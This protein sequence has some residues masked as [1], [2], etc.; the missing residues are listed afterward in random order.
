M[1]KYK[2]GFTMLELSVTLM[3][4]GMMLAAMMSVGTAKNE[5]Q[6]IQITRERMDRIQEAITMFYISNR[7]LPCPASGTASLNSSTFGREQPTVSNHAGANNSLQLTSAVKCNN[8]IYSYTGALGLGMPDLYIGVVPTRSLNL[9]DMY[10]FDGWGNRITYSVSSYCIARLNWSTWADT[11]YYNKYKCSSNGLLTG[12]LTALN[13]TD[14]SK[15]TIRDASSAWM[16]G[17]PYVVYTIISHGKNGI[18]SWNR[19]GTRVAGS[20][21]TTTAEKANANLNSSTGAALASNSTSIT[22]TYYDLPYND[23]ATAGANYF[24]DIIRWK[25]AQQIDYAASH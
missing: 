4:S 20:A 18:G 9:P 11:T 10:M 14:G 15:I 2:Y 16:T 1:P 17:S 3:L 13:L 23:E 19:V 21:S 25:T 6:K 12:L 8:V 7:Y 5:I 22:S 24:D